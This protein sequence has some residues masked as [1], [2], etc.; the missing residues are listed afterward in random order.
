[1]LQIYFQ[2]SVIE[3]VD[4]VG[5]YICTVFVVCPIL[6]AVSAK[7]FFFLCDNVLI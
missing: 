2:L 1:M 4:E 7:Y 3:V 6:V 5:L